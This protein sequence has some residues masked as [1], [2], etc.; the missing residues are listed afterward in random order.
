MDKLLGDLSGRG[1]EVYLDDIVIHAE[2]REKHD[3]LVV[4]VFRRLNENKMYVNAKKLQLAKK[5]IK[6][7]GLIV[8][9]ETQKVTEKAR[10]DI[11]EYPEPVDK[12]SLR[13]FLGKMNF[14]SSFIKDMSKIAVP[15]YEKTGKYVQF[16]WTEQMKESFN[17]L[18]EQLAEEIKLYLPDYEK[19]FTLETDASDTGIGAVLLQETE[20]GRIMPIRWAS[21]KL[22]KAEKN[23]GITEKELLAVVWGITHF[24]YQLRGR[25]FSLITDH[26]A[27]EFI[28]DKDDFG[29][30][31]MA[32]WI[33]KIQEYDFDITY[34][35]GEEVVGAD[36]LSRL[37]EKEKETDENEMRRKTR[38]IHEK[39]VAQRI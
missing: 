25:K 23:Y 17:K 6:L 4:E 32:R 24:E 37:Y 34:K 27:L 39:N 3:E 9:G 31:R 38:E 33:E 1:V 36:A 19:K 7:L 13:R 30:R 29:N 22:N 8:D 18:K 5:E 16:E 2:E 15:L 14:Y 11:L 12:K 26:R 21:R 35:K 10:A 28:K 20:D